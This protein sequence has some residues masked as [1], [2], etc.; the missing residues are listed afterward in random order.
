M[1]DWDGGQERAGSSLLA[2]NWTIAADELREE[3]I[4]SSGP[5][6]QNVNKVAT[7]VR[8][9]F[10]LAGSLSLPEDVKQRLA[11][12][13]GKRLTTEGELLIESQ[14]YRTQEQNRRAARERLA[15]LIQAAAE[16]P[17]PRHKTQPTQAARRRR[18]EEKK[19]RGEVKRLRQRKEAEW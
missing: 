6:G 12:I 1:D 19:R 8:L 15:N 3:F 14:H 11:R 5:G 18:L 16:G 7:A 17:R 4:Q 10:N 9:R 2:G 13:A